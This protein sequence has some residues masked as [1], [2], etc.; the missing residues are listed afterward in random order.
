MKAVSL[1]IPDS[2]W[3]AAF[4][5]TQDVVPNELQHAMAGIVAKALY[6][7]RERCAF[8]ARQQADR[9]SGDHLVPEALMEVEEAIL[10]GWE[11]LEE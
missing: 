1:T 4:K 7:E 3:T 10:E 2:L 5:A 11:T 8:L 6:F 9:S